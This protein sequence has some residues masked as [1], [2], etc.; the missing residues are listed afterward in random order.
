MQG[1]TVLRTAVQC[2]AVR[3]PPHQGVEGRSGTWRLRMWGFKI[4]CSKPLTHI[5]LGVRSPNLQSLRVNKL[6]SSNP[7]SSNTTSLNSR[8]LALTLR[9]RGGQVRARIRRQGIVL[10]HRNFLQK[11]TMPR[12]RMMPLPM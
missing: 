5:R 1:S 11:T 4:L 10:K 9:P 6:L 3:P 8:V 7:T 12:R 2:S